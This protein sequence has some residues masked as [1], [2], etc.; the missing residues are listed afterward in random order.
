MNLKPYGGMLKREKSRN[1]RDKKLYFSTFLR[2]ILRLPSYTHLWE[3]GRIIELE[4]VC[5]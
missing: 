3:D 1:N 5:Y 2:I 4:G